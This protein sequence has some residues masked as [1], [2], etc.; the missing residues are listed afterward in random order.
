MVSTLDAHRSEKARS[1]SLM[2]SPGEHLR[3][4]YEVE[5]QLGPRTFR[6]LDL[7]EGKTVAIKVVASGEQP[8]GRRR[9]TSLPGLPRFREVLDNLVVFDFIL[10]LDLESEVKRQPRPLPPAKILKRF[11]SVLGLVETLHD[12]R[13]VHGDIKPANLLTD[14]HDRFWLVDWGSS[15][16][17]HNAGALNLFGSPEKWRG[18]VS[19]QSDQYALAQ[20]LAFMLTSRPPIPPQLADLHTYGSHLVTVLSRAM[21]PSPQHRYPDLASFRAHLVESLKE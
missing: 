11:L 12:Q 13:M 15:A 4:R 19:A 8:D 6:A 18:K 2:F 16:V 3:Q 7:C 21:A 17:G 20:V 14:I 1:A 9:A 5:R 10:G